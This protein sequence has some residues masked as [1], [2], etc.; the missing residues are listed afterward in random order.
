MLSS[1]EQDDL[2]HT[3]L[4][5]A[6]GRALISELWSQP[7]FTGHSFNPYMYPSTG[8]YS[9]LSQCP[10]GHRTLSI[11]LVLSCFPF[12]VPPIL[13]LLRLQHQPWQVPK[14]V[15]CYMSVLVSCIVDRKPT[16]TCV[17]PQPLYSPFSS[18]LQQRQQKT[19]EKKHS[20]LNS[21][22]T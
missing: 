16:T 20:E 13:P 21:T 3:P 2:L 18:S 9:S 22:F 14:S 19:Y 12:Y 4:N 10:Q 17:T 6:Q 5:N 11:I 8:M 7:R 15:C 1:E